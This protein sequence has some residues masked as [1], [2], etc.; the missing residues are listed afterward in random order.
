MR[1]LKSSGCGKPSPALKR[2]ANAMSEILHDLG[3][4]ASTR[5]G[6][7]VGGALTGAGM[8]N[9]DV[10]VVLAAVPVLIG[11]CLDIAV[12]YIQHRFFKKE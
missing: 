7:A 6:T 12:R 4:V 11:F 2:K 8:A 10:S 3:S 5:L 9:D 1:A